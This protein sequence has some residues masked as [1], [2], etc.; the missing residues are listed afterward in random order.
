MDV[1]NHGSREI[2]GKGD[3]RR[4]IDEIEK[5]GGIGKNDEELCGLI[6]MRD[7]RREVI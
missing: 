3:G 4:R 2:K 7:T 5:S 1:S 6:F